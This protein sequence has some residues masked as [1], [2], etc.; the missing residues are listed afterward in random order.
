M[1]GINVPLQPV[2]HQ[3][4][5]TEKINGLSPD[6][7]TIRDPTPHVFQGRSRRPRDRRLRAR[8]HRL[9]HR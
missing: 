6:A 8:P 3:Y 4:I 7:A 9:D 5:V 2:K 1:A